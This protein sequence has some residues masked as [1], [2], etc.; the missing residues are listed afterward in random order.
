MPNHTGRGNL[1]PKKHTIFIH[2]RGDIS[3]TKTITN[4]ALSFVLIVSSWGNYGQ[5][6]LQ[7]L[8]IFKNFFLYFFLFSFLFFIPIL[9]ILNDSLSPV[10]KGNCRML[11]PSLTTEI[12]VI[13]RE[14][15]TKPLNQGRVVHGC[16]K[17][18][19]KGSKEEQKL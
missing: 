2:Y 7:N 18:G 9:R 16:Q 10:T 17:R 19:S 6:F 1:K 14:T 4:S 15:Y 13:R 3:A 11:V 5:I 12:C 8:S